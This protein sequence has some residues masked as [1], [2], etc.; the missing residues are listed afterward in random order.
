MSIEGAAPP[1]TVQAVVER[2][3]HLVL[4]VDARVDVDERAEPVEP[5]HGKS[6][7]R[8]GA[9]IASRTLDPE[10][11]DGAPRDRIEALALARGVAAGVVRVPG[12]GAETVRA[13]DE[14]VDG[15]RPVCGHR[16]LAVIALTR[17]SCTPAG[18]R[19]TLSLRADRVVIPGPVI[20]AH[21]IGVEPGRDADLSE[22]RPHVS[23]ERIH[24]DG[25]RAEHVTGALSIRESTL[26][27]EQRLGRRFLHVHH[28]PDLP[29]DLRLD[30]VTLV[31]HER[32]LAW[33]GR[34]PRL[35][36]PPT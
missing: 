21:R 13:R 34:A 5:Q 2:L 4:T 11:I 17:L 30:V 8:Q 18:L 26:V 12:I 31:E 7:G 19:P 27:H 16:H 6:R 25:V 3:D 22:H 15:G 36:V 32:D 28:R 24:E 10:Q 23:C 9:E 29:C 1:T 14:V 35:G 20:G 33:R